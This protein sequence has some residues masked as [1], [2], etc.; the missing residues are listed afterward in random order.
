M[1]GKTVFKTVLILLA[2]IIIPAM[3]YTALWFSF[4]GEVEKTLRQTILQAA[5]E[6][7]LLDGDFSPV[8][9]FPG[10]YRT[11]F[12]GTMSFDGYTLRIP[13]A[14]LQS[15]FLPKTALTIDMPEG[16]AIEGT[17]EPDIN[18]I[19]ALYVSL[20]VPENLPAGVTRPQL[21]SWKDSGGSIGVHDYRVV[22]ESL[23]VEG[24]GVFKLDDNLQPAGKL[25]A[26]LTGGIEFIAWLKDNGI[27]ESKDAIIAS[28]VLS[29]LAR[30]DEKTG[31]RTVKAALTLQNRMLFLGPLRLL[32]VPPVEWPLPQ[33]SLPADRIEAEQ[34]APPR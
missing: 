18:N 24:R 22:K 23:T 33:P 3:A 6:G 17:A 25:S 14:M 4:K 1:T 12:S 10:P 7:V 8:T 15:F 9:G 30:E 34:P 11:G 32:S 31:V 21:Q 26:H 2:V 5:Q 29:G 28:A 16:A 13:R 20:T 27:I 19:D